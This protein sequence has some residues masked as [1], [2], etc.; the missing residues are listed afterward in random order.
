MLNSSIKYYY[1]LIGI[2]AAWCPTSK[3]EYFLISS[4]SKRK[5][6]PIKKHSVCLLW[7]SLLF[8]SFIRYYWW[9]RRNT[10]LRSW[11]ADGKTD[12]WVCTKNSSFFLTIRR[13]HW[14]DFW[15]LYLWLVH[16]DTNITH[17]G[18]GSFH[19]QKLCFYFP[20]IF[21]SYPFKERRDHF[22]LLLCNS[23]CKSQ[24]FH[25]F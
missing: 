23:H 4:K 1:F 7:G 6:A 11:L 19:K 17:K 15:N 5:L 13:R 2:D 3:M 21:D 14:P 22:S 24:G 8:A 10:A 9:V 20:L 12:L 16:T 25:S 18:E